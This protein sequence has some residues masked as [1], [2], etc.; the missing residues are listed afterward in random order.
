MWLILLLEF[1]ASGF[2]AGVYCNWFCC[3]ILLREFVAIDFIVRICCDFIVKMN[4]R[5]I[6]SSSSMCCIHSW[7]WLSTALY[8]LRP[9]VDF[10]PLL[11][12]LSSL[13]HHPFIQAHQD[14]HPS[15]INSRL[16]FFLLLIIILIIT[17]EG[18]SLHL[19][20]SKVL[21]SCYSKNLC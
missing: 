18:M 14:L 8:L 12:L 7:S 19:P 15:P 2:V 17:V 4:C 5:F 1:I 6:S 16:F 21:I 9:L 13:F 10:L 11:R 20:I 3:E